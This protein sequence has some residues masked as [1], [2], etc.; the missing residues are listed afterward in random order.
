MESYARDSGGILGAKTHEA[1]LTLHGAHEEAKRKMK[2]FGA[3]PL[4]PGI[5][6][7]AILEIGDDNEICIGNNPNAT[8][9]DKNFLNTIENGKLSSFLLVGRPHHHL[10]LTNLSCKEK[11]LRGPL[12]TILG[13]PDKITFNN[14]D[15][16]LRKL[17]E[18]DSEYQ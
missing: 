5:I 3:I 2:P 13:E 1:L 11:K 6:H 7:N 9:S 15:D 17:R 16:V 14:S 10:R 18:T 8:K 4:L 12:K